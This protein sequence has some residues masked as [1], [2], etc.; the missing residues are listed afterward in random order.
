MPGG[1]PLSAMAEIG[2]VVERGRTAAGVLMTAVVREVVL[3]WLRSVNM[4][5]EGWGY[6][7][8]GC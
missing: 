3:R 5:L 8:E 7:L 1:G 2:E 4:V 6:R